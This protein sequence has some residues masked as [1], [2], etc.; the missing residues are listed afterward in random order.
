MTDKLSTPHRAYLRRRAALPL[1][2]ILTGREM[3]AFNE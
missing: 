3:R 2:L 1:A